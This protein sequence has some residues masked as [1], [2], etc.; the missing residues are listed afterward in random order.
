MGYN[1]GNYLLHDR[2]SSTRKK[3]RN[4]ME[5][6]K[7]E[8]TCGL[9]HE[10]SPKYGFWKYRI[11]SVGSEIWFAMEICEIRVFGCKLAKQTLG[12]GEGQGSQLV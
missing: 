2:N 6:D 4:L 3:C 12:G 8:Y 10:R 9:F 7:P 11:E 1:N 5:K